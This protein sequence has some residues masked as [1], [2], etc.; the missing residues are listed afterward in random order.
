MKR[1]P[2]YDKNT[3]RSEQVAFLA[4]ALA[5]AS[6]TLLAFFNDL[7]TA[8]EPEHRPVL[9]SSQPVATTDEEQSNGTNL[10][11]TNVSFIQTSAPS[12]QAPPHRSL[13]APEG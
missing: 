12:G 13:A 11:Q 1:L 4:L 5:A 3:G 10:A 2:G 9:G 7:Q 8:G 6:L